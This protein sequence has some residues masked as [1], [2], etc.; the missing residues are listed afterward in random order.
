MSYSPF[1]NLANYVQAIQV[2]VTALL[3]LQLLLGDC[4]K[5]WNINC[6]KPSTDFRLIHLD[7]HSG[8]LHV[9][10]LACI[11]IFLCLFAQMMHSQEAFGLPLYL[12]F[13]RFK[14]QSS[15]HRLLVWGWGHDWNVFLLLPYLEVKTGRSQSVWLE[16]SYKNVK[17]CHFM[18]SMK[19]G[20]LDRSHL[21][22]SCSYTRRDLRL[23]LSI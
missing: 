19:T 5:L 14:S 12:Y 23:L 9:L 6:Y 3:L 11:D 13:I 1:C 4:S 2:F 18:P 7:S 15:F 21:V 16:I 22:L 20:T 8:F 17:I 10:S